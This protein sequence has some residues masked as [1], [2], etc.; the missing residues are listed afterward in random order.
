[1]NSG[2]DADNQIDFENA[3]CLLNSEVAVLLE[4][5]QQALAEEETELQRY[6]N[7]MMELIFPAFS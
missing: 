2:I 5:A 1:M 6:S 3:R 4:Q 7:K